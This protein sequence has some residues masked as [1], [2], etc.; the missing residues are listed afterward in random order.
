MC[1]TPVKRAHRGEC[2][3]YYTSLKLM[4]VLND[5]LNSKFLLLNSYMSF[6]LTVPKLHTR[7]ATGKAEKFPISYLGTWQLRSPAPVLAGVQR[8][9]LGS[10]CGGLGGLRVPAN[11]TYAQ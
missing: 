10:A 4:N 8:E 7:D 1:F 2:M 11:T 6:S 5:I 3:S 9:S